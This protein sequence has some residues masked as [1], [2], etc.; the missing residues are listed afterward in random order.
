MTNSI[1]IIPARSGSKRINS[2]NIKNF[3]GI[4]ML[5]RA[6]ITAQSCK[7]IDEVFVSTDCENIAEMAKLWGASAPFIREENLSDDFTPTKPVIQDTIERLKKIYPKKIYDY[8]L[9][10]Y[11]CTPF[12]KSR[13]LESAFNK[14]F[15]LNYEMLF[16]IELY[17]HPIQRA[18]ELGENNVKFRE[19]EFELTRTQ[20]LNT[21]Y[22]DA[23]QFYL[24]STNS[25]ISDKAL[26]SSANGII[27]ENDFFMDID[28]PEDW[29]M[30]E[31]VF[32]SLFVDRRTDD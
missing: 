27:F 23:G 19:P 14:I 1:C 31:V 15:G 3:C 7:F 13:H 10:L 8:V 4:P 20:D 29:R 17:K 16:P 12:I 25:W 9:C 5:K 24:G 2:K 30:A 28:T 22:H 11:P 18:F 6:I 21:Y 32:N 26:H